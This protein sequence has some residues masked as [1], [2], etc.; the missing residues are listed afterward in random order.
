MKCIH[1]GAECMAQRGNLGWTSDD[2]IRVT[3]SGTS[4]HSCPTCDA[5]ILPPR[6]NAWLARALEEKREIGG[7]P[8]L[9]LNA[10]T[11]AHS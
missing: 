3:I 5:A 9:F 2:G 1:C 8:Y 11:F 7:S 10:A 6:L 4:F